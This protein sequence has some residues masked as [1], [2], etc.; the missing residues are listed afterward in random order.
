M[1]HQLQMK[2]LLMLSNESTVDLN[3]LAESQELF[4]LMKEDATYAEL[5]EWV[6]ENF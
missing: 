3:L 4:D 1:T 5:L 6:N 2:T